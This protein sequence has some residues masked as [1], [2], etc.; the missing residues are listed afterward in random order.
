MRTKAQLIQDSIPGVKANLRKQFDWHELIHALNDL[1]SPYRELIINNIRF[2][3]NEELSADIMQAVETY[4]DIKA[5]HEATH[6][7]DDNQLTLPEIDLI[8]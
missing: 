5:E 2:H 4:L 7:F 1:S 6:L 8:L 3:D